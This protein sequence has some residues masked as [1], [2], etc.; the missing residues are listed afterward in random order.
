MM[1]CIFFQPS[2][3]F[4]II[5]L[6]DSGIVVCIIAGDAWVT[7]YIAHNIHLNPFGNFLTSLLELIRILWVI[8]IDK[9]IVLFDVVQRHIERYSV[10]DPFAFGT[11]FPH[12][13]RQGIE[14][15]SQVGIE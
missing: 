2:D 7:Q 15:S 11:Y 6:V 14:R 9:N 1:W 5:T 4:F 3:L 10:V 8:G 12:A 13:G